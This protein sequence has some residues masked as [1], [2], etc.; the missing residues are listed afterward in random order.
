MNYGLCADVTHLSEVRTTAILA[1]DNALVRTGLRAVLTDAGIT[2]LAEAATGPDLLREVLRHRP[3]VLVLGTVSPDTLRDVSQ[4]TPGIAILLV[5]A[6]EDTQTVRRA[7]RAGVHGYLPASADDIARAVSVVAA[8]WVIFSRAALSA[9]TG[10]SADSR[11][12]PELTTREFEVLDLVAAG[13]RNSVVARRLHLAPKTV[14]NHISNIFAKLGVCD[15]AT[16]IVRAREAG[17]G[18]DPG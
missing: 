16:A 9:L 17:L 4:V 13:L 3:D 1:D 18:V 7:L 15:R 8:G 10:E 6:T 12:F 14:S 5:N 11:P 2:V